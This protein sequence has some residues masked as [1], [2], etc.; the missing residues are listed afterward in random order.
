MLE[1]ELQF[2]RGAFFS[3]NG[4][5]SIYWDNFFFIFTNPLTWL[6]F[7]FC[8]LWVFS[9]KKNWKEVVCVIIMVGLL[10]LL[11]DRISSGFFKPYFHRFRPSHHPDF[12]NQVKIVFNKRGG[13]YGFISG[14]ATN[15]FGLATFFTMIFR[16]KLFTFTIFTFAVLI[17]YS[18]IYLGLHFISDVVAGAIVGSLIG[19]F[20]YRIYQYSR[21]KWLKS[22]KTSAGLVF[23]PWEPYFLCVVF[24]AHLT[25]LLLFSNQLVKVYY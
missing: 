10:I 3:L 24:A 21:Y 8:F 5:N 1:K 6:F 15:L 11:C 20:V 25:I 17:A 23:S 18:R 13:N 4:S 12:M 19:Y 14:H 9:Y 16:N 2:E 7:F 22:E